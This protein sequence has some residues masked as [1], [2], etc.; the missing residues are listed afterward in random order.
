MPAASSPTRSASPTW[1]RA[2]PRC[3][4]CARR[5]RRWTFAA[6][7]D[8][9]RCLPFPLLGIDLRQRRRV[10]QR[11]PRELVQRAAPHLH[12]QSR[13]REERLLLSSSRRTGAWC[14]A[15]PA[16]GVTT[17]RS[18]ANSS[19]PSTPTCASCVN[20]FLPSVKLLAKQRTGAKV[21]KRYDKALTPHE[22]LLA[23]GALDE[24]TAARLEARHLPL[25]P[26]ALLYTS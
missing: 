6:L 13:L 2:G 25:N 3:A 12:A 10:H 4:S 21:Y 19:P 1:P 9:R 18:S 24:A 17:P 7:L 11:P 15:R 16:T 22:R 8:V 26:A 20:F 23:L 5:A 14:A